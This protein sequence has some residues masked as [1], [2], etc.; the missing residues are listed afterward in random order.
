MYRKLQDFLEAYETLSTGTQRVLDS[1]G[2][3]HLGQRITDG[4]RSLGEIAWHITVTVPEMM[5]HTGLGIAAVDHE[6]APPTSAKVIADAYRDASAELKR[7][8]SASWDDA[9]LELFDNLYG[10]EWQRGRTL[11]ILIHHEIHHRAQAMVLMRQA[12]IAVPGL[13]GPAKE[14]WAQMGMNAPAY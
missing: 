8:V 1:I 9:S 2:D 7:Q 3:E 11:E 12:G 5:Q 13:F 4:H 14:E 10:E 6:A